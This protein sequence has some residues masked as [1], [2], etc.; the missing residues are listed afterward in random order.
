MLSL[1]VSFP[2]M[3]SPGMIP[4]G[5]FPRLVRPGMQQQ[6]PLADAGVIPEPVSKGDDGDKEKPKDESDKNDESSKDDVTNKG[7]CTV[8]CTLISV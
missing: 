5:L 3:P 7:I 6:P 1:F 4:P 8:C 2:G